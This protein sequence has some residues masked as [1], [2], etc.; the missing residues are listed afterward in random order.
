M[1]MARAEK[2]GLKGGRKIGQ[3]QRG[4]TVE[5][6]G[7]E[8]TPE[9]ISSIKKG[10]KFAMVADTKQCN[11]AIAIAEDADIMV[12]EATYANDQEEKANKFKHLTA[13]QAAGIA[14]QAGAKK[15]V[16]TH[17]SQ[18]YTT[19]DPHLQEAKVLHD[20]TVIAHDFMKFSL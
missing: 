3:L 18:R 19:L 9:M 14:Q 20:N 4:E 16:L 5:V 7:N 10:K 1:D 15:L 13:Q 12:C 6:E 17:F 2:L 8:V 11:G